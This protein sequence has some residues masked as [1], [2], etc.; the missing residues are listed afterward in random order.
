M[1]KRDRL[2]PWQERVV[3]SLSGQQLVWLLAHGKGCTSQNATAPDIPAWSPNVVLI[4]PN[5]VCL[6]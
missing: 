4:W 6:P 2:L 1:L 3:N 5:P